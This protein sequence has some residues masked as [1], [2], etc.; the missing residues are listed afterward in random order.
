[1][2][3]QAFEEIPKVW[4]IHAQYRGSENLKD[5]EIFGGVV[6]AATTKCNER[7]T[8]F[9]I[10][11]LHNQLGNASIHLRITSKCMK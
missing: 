5:F 1:M 6:A 7:I 4:K 11:V 10:E 9:F 8:S 3:W 2:V